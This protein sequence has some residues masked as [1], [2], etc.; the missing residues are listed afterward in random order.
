MICQQGGND[1][2]LWV[3][4]EGRVR[5]CKKSCVPFAQFRFPP[6]FC[7]VA[8]IFFF[9]TSRR[10][11]PNDRGEQQQQHRMAFAA[12]CVLFLPRCFCR[13]VGGPESNSLLHTADDL[14]V[15]GAIRLTRLS[16]FAGSGDCFGELA[17]ITG[18]PRSASAITTEVLK[19]F[20]LDYLFDSAMAPRLTPVRSPR[21][22]W[23]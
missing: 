16:S 15:S 12:P 1:G 7:A 5:L 4:K 8:D 2:S 3:I 22:C 17:L 6:F 23:S 13:F 11:S 10:L 14:A 18:L 21:C 9:A 19:A 20:S